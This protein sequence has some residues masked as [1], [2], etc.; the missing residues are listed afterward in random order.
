[1]VM[2]ERDNCTN[3][4]STH[5][6]TELDTRPGELCVVASMEHPI[7]RYILSCS[8]SQAF[9]HSFNPHV[10]IVFVRPFVLIMFVLNVL[11]TENV[12]SFIEKILGRY[13]EEWGL[14]RL[15][16]ITFGSPLPPFLHA[17]IIAVHS[18][19][20]YMCASRAF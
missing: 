3:V 14:R 15:R 6:I 1:V 5:S 2:V 10:D 20:S 12:I 4:Y 13:H 18:F 8:S 17:M 16:G 19:P 11:S 7:F 9:I